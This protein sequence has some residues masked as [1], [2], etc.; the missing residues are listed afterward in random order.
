MINGY[1]REELAKLIWNKPYFVQIEL[2]RNCNYKCVFCFENC[3]R[4]KKYEDIIKEKWKKVIDELYE[5]GIKQ[6]HFSGG[7]NFLYKDFNEIVKYTKEKGFNVLINT[8]G[9]FD[10][11]NIIKYSD[12][13]VFSVHGTANIHDNIT[14]M[15]GAFD[16]AINNIEKAL[17]ASKS[18]LINTVLIKDNFYEYL[19]LYNFLN[20]KYPNIKYA[21]TLAIPCKTGKKFEDRNILLTRSNLQY[22]K[23]ILETIGDEKLVY[24]HGMYGLCGIEYNKKEFSMPVCAAGKSK[25]II[26]Y[27]GDVY[28]CNF[29]QSREYMCGNVFEENISSIWKNGKG[30]KEF[31]QYYLNENLPYECS[32][33]KKVNN[34]YSGCRAWTNSYIEGKMDINVER[35]DRCEPLNAFV[36]N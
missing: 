3:D 27:N 25:M 4:E 16:K 11:D 18:V 21:P 33:C 29:F 36:G 12:D 24:K 34:C 7:E 10:I 17:R 30:F 8:N 15:R 6:I 32:K 22:Y 1:N 35:D 31:R 28:P 20:S 13:F 19:D 14:R 9:Y 23:K 5:L 26:K 2:T